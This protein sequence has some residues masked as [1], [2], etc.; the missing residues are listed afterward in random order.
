MDKR[1]VV[2]K[3]IHDNGAA[4]FDL[5]KKDVILFDGGLFCIEKEK[6]MR[7][8]MIGM[9]KLPNSNCSQV[10]FSK[11]K[12]PTEEFKATL[13]FTDIDATINYFK[14]M[15]KMLNSLG[16]KTGYG[17]RNKRKKVEVGKKA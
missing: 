16:Y 15:K 2:E 13:W 9:K 1:K 14:R 6:V 3:W 17:K 11:K 8:K 4:D 5:K 7:S 12:Y 10:I